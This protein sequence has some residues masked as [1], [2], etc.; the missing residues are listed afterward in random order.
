[1]G[2]SDEGWWFPGLARKAH[3]FRDGRSLCGSWGTFGRPTLEPDDRESVDDCV[4]C[5][6]KR[7]K[8]KK[9]S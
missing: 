5:R 2:Q 8:E 6:R 9:T 7:D 4:Q 1:M 3:Y